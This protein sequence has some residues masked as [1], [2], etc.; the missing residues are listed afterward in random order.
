[1]MDI[2]P[3]LH[4][5][6]VVAGKMSALAPYREPDRERFGWAAPKALPKSDT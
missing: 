4:M 2:G 3:V 5:D 6:D 1:M